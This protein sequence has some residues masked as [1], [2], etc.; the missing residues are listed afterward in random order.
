MD[1]EWRSDRRT[2]A[3]AT[4][5]EARLLEALATRLA[6]WP[7]VPPEARPLDLAE[8][9]ARARLAEARARQA[10]AGALHAPVARVGRAR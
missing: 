8:A 7:G 2:N 6:R 9:R 3:P 1:R 5:H 10:P 4:V